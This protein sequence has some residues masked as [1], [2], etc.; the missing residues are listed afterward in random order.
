MPFVTGVLGTISKGLVKGSGRKKIRFQGE[1]MQTTASLRSARTVRGVQ[2]IG[3]N[4][5]S[6]KLQW[7]T[8]A[9]A[10]VENYTNCDWCFWYSN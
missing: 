6:L 8:I 3:G 7:E 2:E 1:T 10:G 9:K 5:H 4:L